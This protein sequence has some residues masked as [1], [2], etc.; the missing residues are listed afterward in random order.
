MLR[1][2]IAWVLASESHAALKMQENMAE[3]V[4]V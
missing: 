3:S 4:E 1:D 2:E